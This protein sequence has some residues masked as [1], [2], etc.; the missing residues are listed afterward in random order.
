MTLFVLLSRSRWNWTGFTNRPLSRSIIGWSETW[1]LKN[2]K[3]SNFQIFC[4]HVFKR[5]KLTQKIQIQ[6]FFAHVFLKNYR[7]K[8]KIWP[9]KMK[10]FKNFFW[11]N[12][13]KILH[14]GTFSWGLFKSWLMIHDSWIISYD[15]CSIFR[16]WAILELVIFN[17]MMYGYIFVFFRNQVWD[18]SLLGRI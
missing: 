11:R 13:R 2:S 16:P 4:N 15:A 3:S 14:M 8:L 18:Q 7:K 12:Q 17:F 1:I 10:I 5:S 9:E 6:I